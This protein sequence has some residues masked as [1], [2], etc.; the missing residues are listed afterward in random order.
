M[1]QS[2]GPL[3]ATGRDAKGRKQYRYHPRWRE[4]RDST[5]YEHIINFGEML[6]IIRERA[7]KDL[8]RRGLPREK[9]LA[10]VV[11]LLDTTLIRIGNEE[12]SRENNSFGLTTL[13]NRHVEVS[14]STLHFHFRGKSGKEHAIDVRDKQ[15]A[16]I[17]KR[18]QELP[19]AEPLR[20]SSTNILQPEGK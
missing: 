5:K 8:A 19:G 12:Y 2:T 14:G 15:L 3:Q 6:P 1:S 16:K 11:R 20:T 7:S 18:R 17:V 13:Q 4:I 10:T 9:V